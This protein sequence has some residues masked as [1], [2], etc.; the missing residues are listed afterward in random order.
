MYIQ[1]SWT[2]SKTGRFERARDLDNTV[3]TKISTCNS[4]TLLGDSCGV[5]NFSSSGRVW[6]SFTDVLISSFDMITV[7]IG[8]VQFCAL[9][10][11]LSVRLDCTTTFYL[12]LILLRL[13]QLHYCYNVTGQSQESKESYKPVR[14]KEVHSNSIRSRLCTHQLLN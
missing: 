14:I 5:S 2:F 13:F 9:F 1:Y 10:A 7:E 11:N 4:I 6:K 12:T 8:F 3:I